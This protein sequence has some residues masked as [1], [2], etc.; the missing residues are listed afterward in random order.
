M[1]TC[2][3]DDALVCL[4]YLLLCPP[5]IFV[6]YFYLCEAFKNMVYEKKKLTHNK[7]LYELQSS[8]TV[9]KNL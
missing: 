1:L 9:P 3:L 5:S 2:G 8:Q 6:C 4:R 7:R